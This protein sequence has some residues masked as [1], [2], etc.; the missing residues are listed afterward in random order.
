MQA[1]LSRAA[2]EMASPAARTMQQIVEES[3]ASRKFQ[4]YLAAAFAVAALLLA[5]LGIYGV[6][7]FSVARRTPEIG[8]RISLGAISGSLPTMI[9]KERMLTDAIPLAPR[10]LLPLYIGRTLS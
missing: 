4:M 5:S 2:P 9:L 8:I 6:I 3:V 7:S 10:H 1:R